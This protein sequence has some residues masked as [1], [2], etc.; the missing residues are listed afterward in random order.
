[1]LGTAFFALALTPSLLP[2]DAF[3]QSVVCGVCAATGYLLGVFARWNWNL[4]LRDFLLPV[5]NK[6]RWKLS[7]TWRRRIEVALLVIA[8]LWL[9]GMVIFA[10]RWQREVAALTDARQLSTAEYFLVFPLGIGLWL[11]LLLLGRG[12]N[13]ATDFLIEHGP[14]RIDV[15]IRTTSAWVAVGLIILVIVNEVVPGTIVNMAEGVF[16]V[17]NQEIREDLSQPTNPERSGSP[18]SL[19]DWEGLGSFGTRFVGLGLHKKE[20]EDL[21]GRPSKEPIRV[22]SGLDHGAD[23]QERAQRVVKELQ[24]TH[25]EDRKVVMV[26]TTTGTGWVNP[27]AAQSLELLYDGDTAIAAA[28]YSYLPSAIQFIAGT[29]MVRDAGET[30]I[31]AVQDWWNELD[32]AT[33]PKLL[34]YGESLGV[35]AGEGAFSGLRGLAQAADGV[36][37]IGPPH[38]SDLWRNFV[39][40]RDPGTPEADPEYA[41]GMVVRF[42]A[43]TEEIDEFLGPQPLWQSTRVLYVQHATDPVVWWTPDVMLKEPDWLKEPAQFDR[44]PAMRWY[45]FVTFFQLSFDLPVAANVPNGHGHNYGSGVLD[46]LAAI[47]NEEKFNREYVDQQRVFLDKAMEHQGPEKEI[48]VNQQQ[49]QL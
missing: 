35:V 49:A 24:R 17:R 23:N 46:G 12:I 22:Y 36:L 19:N 14:Q 38:S 41:A 16:S 40:R 44:S 2:R 29:E 25:A 21:T 31:R 45:P 10:V 34:I 28:Q 8:L 11:L 42:A 37:W 33:R 43:N 26:A 39:S 18:D 32:P 20:L 47:S 27:T 1:M 30:L 5:W 15:G 9:A 4:W 48:G 3:Y 6:R 13:A 7:D